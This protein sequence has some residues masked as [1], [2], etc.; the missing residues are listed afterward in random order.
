MYNLSYYF[1]FFFE[2]SRIISRYV[3]NDVTVIAVNLKSK[4]RV[5]DDL[6]FYVCRKKILKEKRR[7]YDCLNCAKK[8]LEVRI[9]IAIKTN[10][11]IE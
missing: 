10:E 6:C 9:T 5:E 8:K 3:K 1:F 4:G 7:Y 2:I 11:Q